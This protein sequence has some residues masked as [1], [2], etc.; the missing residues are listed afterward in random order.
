VA[1]A[2]VA[3]LV[4]LTLRATVGLEGRATLV[5]ASRPPRDACARRVDALFPEGLQSV[6][7][8]SE[9]LDRI[10]HSRTRGYFEALAFARG[11]R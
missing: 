9:R 7:S 5:P 11:R 10:V 8:T 4:V 2:V 1:S 3:A 6:P